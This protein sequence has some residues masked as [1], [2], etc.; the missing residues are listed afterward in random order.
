M[1]TEMIKLEDASNLR[2]GDI[3]QHFKHTDIDEVNYRYRIDGFAEHTESGEQLVIY[4]A[5]YGDKKTYARPIEMFLSEVDHEK[6]PNVRQRYR[7]VKIVCVG[8]RD[9]CWYCGNQLIWHGDEDDG[10]GG[11]V[12]TLSCTHCGAEV[13]Y[14]WSK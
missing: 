5:L 6:Y 13:T 4:T 9:S 7:F 11:I 2:V 8:A 1:I 12:T 14:N 10:D 3:V